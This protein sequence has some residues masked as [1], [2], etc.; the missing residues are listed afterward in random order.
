ME[1]KWGA[2]KEHAQVHAAGTARKGK[3]GTSFHEFTSCGQSLLK[4]LLQ[5]QYSIESLPTAV[6]R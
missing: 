3:P 4:N 2:D 1:M 5:Y 6:I